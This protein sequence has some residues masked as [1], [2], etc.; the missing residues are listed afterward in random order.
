MAPNRARIYRSYTSPRSVSGN[1]ARRRKGRPQPRMGF[2]DTLLGTNISESTCTRK[3]ARSP[4][5]VLKQYVGLVPTGLE[6]LDQYQLSGPLEFGAADDE[7]VDA[8]AR[9][10]PEPISPIPDHSV[11]AR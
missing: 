6:L 10:F 8:A 4:N 2:S 11:P 5:P 3:A 1:A 9:P 7:E